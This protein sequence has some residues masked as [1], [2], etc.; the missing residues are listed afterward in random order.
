MP[1]NTQRQIG[2]LLFIVIAA[3][4]GAMPAAAETIPGRWELV[5]ALEP[6]TAVAVKSFG[7]EPVEG[8]YL[9]MD[10]EYLIL[11]DPQN[12]E[13]RIL[14]NQVIEVT[15]LNTKRFWTATKFGAIAGFAAGL[16]A[17]LAAG[18]DGVFEDAT[19]GGNGLILG[20]IGAGAGALIGKAVEA[21]RQ[22]QVV[23]Y[24]SAVKM[25]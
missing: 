12:P 11:S 1:R 2:V 22:K 13:I 17:G 5:A 23:I 25:E 7:N 16:A 6:G 4:L 15:R 18:D 10:P 9:K 21:S 24:R 19:A 8:A 14:K 3:L 20:A